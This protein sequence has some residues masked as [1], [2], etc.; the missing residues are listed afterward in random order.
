MLHGKVRY[1]IPSRFLDEIPDGLVK[2]LNAKPKAQTNMYGSRSQPNYNELPK[3]MGKVSTEQKDAMPWKVG[4]QV[5]H[6]KFGNGV[7]VS[8]EGNTNDMRVQVNF[9]NEGL[10]WLALEFAK[11][12]P[13]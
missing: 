5:M 3:R 6:K 13:I 12:D 9:G 1:G 8:Y 4:Q 10:K 7:V 2:H 11:L